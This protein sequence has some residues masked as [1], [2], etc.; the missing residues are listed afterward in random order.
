MSTILVIDDEPAILGV[1]RT[2]LRARGY[3]VVTAATGEAGLGQAALT[4]PDVV[5]LDLGLP[6]MD[7][8][9][10][11]RQLRSWSDVPVVVLSVVDSEFTKIE[12]LDSGADDYITKPFAMGELQ[13]RI[14]VALRHRHRATASDPV[15]RVGDLEVDLAA[16]RV[17][18]GMREVQ[19]TAREFDL[20]AYLARNAGKVVTHQMLLRE[21]WGIG[22]ANELNYLRVYVNRLRTKL[23][24]SAGLLRTNPGIGYQLISPTGC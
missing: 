24:D 5:V 12:V 1:L 19:L 10:V 3:E 8:I 16:R 7:G 22:F 14:R 17:V 20:L 18:V 21:V 2:G 11:C 15:V 9:D 6:D 4:S 23:D 13:A